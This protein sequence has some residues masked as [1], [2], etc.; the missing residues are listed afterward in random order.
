PHQEGPGDGAAERRG[1]EVGTPGGADVERAAGQRGQPLLHQHRAAVDHAGELGAVRQRT[2]GHRRDVGL[3]VLAEVGRVGAGHGTLV[4]HPRDGDGGVEPTGEGDAD[5][6]TDGQRGE[7]LGHKKSMHCNA[8][9]CKAPIPTFSPSSRLTPVTGLP[10]RASRRPPRAST[11]RWSR[12][13]PARRR[14]SS[15][16]RGTS[17]Y[18]LLPAGSSWHLGYPWR[19]CLL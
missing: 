19:R 5:P 8:W 3:V 1:V 18:A 13:S 9:S 10:S 15:A 14:W 11:S 6:L 4:A 16:G 12:R 17:G 7:N 2:T